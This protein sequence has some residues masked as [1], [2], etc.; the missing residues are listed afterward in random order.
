MVHLSSDFF[1]SLRP[2]KKFPTVSDPDDRIHPVTALDFDSTG[3]F[4]VTA[5]EGGDSIQV[6]GCEA[7]EAGRVVYSKK[8]GV[9][10][11]KF[12]HRSSTVLYTTTKTKD[13]DRKFQNHNNNGAYTY[14]NFIN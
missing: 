1:T 6:F 14:E 10:R 4:L 9:G 5:S 7:G 2:T 3:E 13:D 8:Y 11:I 12:A